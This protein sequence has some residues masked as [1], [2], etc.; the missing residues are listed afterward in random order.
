MCWT[1]VMTNRPTNPAPSDGRP[2]GE[3]PGQVRL[4]AILLLGLGGL[5]GI[6]AILL[7][8]GR[9]WIAGSV[10]EGQEALGETVSDT[11]TL[12]GDLALVAL[13]FIVLAALSIV[14]G[15][16]LRQGRSWARLAGIGFGALLGVLGV[17]YL[18][19]GV[20]DPVSLVIPVGALGVAVTVVSGLLS[21][22]AAE[23]FR[24]RPA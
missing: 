24:D 12:S 20:G 14:V 8:L 1:N 5:L 11:D 18:L 19:A 22:A 9:G 2:A 16:F 23:W 6:V 3:M 13:V 7:F 10:A 4:A 21:G 15:Y 17:R